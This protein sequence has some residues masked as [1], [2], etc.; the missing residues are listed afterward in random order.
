MIP[1]ALHG[2]LTLALPWTFVD[3]PL[4]LAGVSSLA[5]A[6]AALRP[7]FSAVCVDA[8]PAHAARC[9]H[10]L[11]WQTAAWIDHRCGLAATGDDGLSIAAADDDAVEATEGA[12][13]PLWD[14]GSSLLA[15]RAEVAAALGLPGP[16]WGI[17]EVERALGLISELQRGRQGGAHGEGFALCPS[18]VASADTVYIVG[19]LSALAPAGR[20]RDYVL[21][22][23]LGCLPRRYHPCPG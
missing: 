9:V 19:N 15:F 22:D 3:V 17:R 8:P 21:R 7:Q 11:A 13:G 16:G 4:D 12:V 1:C 23:V 10:D 18:A 6:A 5:A 20:Y 14:A 2:V